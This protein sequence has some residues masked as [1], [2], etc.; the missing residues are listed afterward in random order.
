MSSKV[1]TSDIICACMLFVKTSSVGFLSF[2]FGAKMKTLP[3]RRCIWFARGI[4]FLSVSQ[5]VGKLSSNNQNLAPLQSLMS[6]HT[7]ST[8]QG[9]TYFQIKFRFVKCFQTGIRPKK[10][11]MPKHHRN[12]CLW[13]TWKDLM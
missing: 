1:V 7:C 4:T 6:L 5:K 9:L 3:N 8:V 2:H 13:K 10:E 12:V 11:R